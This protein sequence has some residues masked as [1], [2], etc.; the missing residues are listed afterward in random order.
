MDPGSLIWGVSVR[1]FAFG[2]AFL[3]F[4][5]TIALM[6][7]RDGHDV[8]HAGP[9]P[10]TSP[11]EDFL[12]EDLTIA[13]GST[14]TWVNKDLTPHTATSGIAPVPSG[15]FDSGILHIDDTYKFTF[16][17]PGTYPYFCSLHADSMQA[18]VVVTASGNEPPLA[19]DD[20]YATEEDTLLNVAAVDGVL[21]NDSDGDGDLLAASLVTDVSNGT[22]NLDTDGSFTYDPTP[23][24]NGTDQFTYAA[25][26]GIADSN[27]ATATII[28]G[29]QAPEAVGNIYTVN[30]TSTLNV[31]AAQGVLANDSNPNGDALE[32]V[33]I[34]DVTLGTLSLSGDGSFTYDPPANA[35]GTDLFTYVAHD[36]E[37]IS[38]LA[39][40]VINVVEPQT[41]TVRWGPITVPGAPVG[42]HRFDLDG[43]V[44]GNPS[45]P[46]CTDCFVT[47][48]DANVVYAD[49]T[50]VNFENGGQ[51]HHTVFA[52]DA[53]ADP[54]CPD[55]RVFGE[56]FFL[57]GSE[58]TPVVLPDG[59]GYY[60]PLGATGWRLASGHLVNF[61]HD[62]KEMYIELTITHVP[63]SQKLKPVTPISLSVPGCGPQDIIVPE[64][65]S[66]TH[67][68]E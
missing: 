53:R 22:L 45:P 17:Q 48:F 26:D 4:V 44:I 41:M 27:E 9:E 5:V 64:G 28:V 1:N 43:I 12:L 34:T 42:E 63:R 11:I 46:P 14:V 21:S 3:A 29:N 18:M 10:V 60:N 68:A 30:Y 62:P 19:V 55:G 67:S 39:A 51:M 65:Y 38:N 66:D 15:V 23:A 7:V 25:N 40:V 37:L 33:L 49:G 16:A 31:P 57:A 8:A 13:V 52:N 24:F 32:A 50:R 54:A 36:G 20:D 59:Y 47:G 58:R 2:L 56:S 61:T 35:T 6:A